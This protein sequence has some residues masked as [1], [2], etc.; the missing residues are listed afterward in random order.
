MRN[1]KALWA[2]IAIVAGLYPWTPLPSRA[3]DGVEELLKNPGFDEELDG[4]PLG[5]H[6][7]HVELRDPSGRTVSHYSQNVLAPAGLTALRIPLAVNEATGAWSVRVC[8]VLTGTA[9]EI[10]F[11]VIVP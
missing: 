3:Q 6:V 1:R 7:L 5:D 9:K 4:Q 10:Q 11:Q 2:V 8:D